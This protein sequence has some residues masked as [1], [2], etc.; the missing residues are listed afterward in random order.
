MQAEQKIMS[1]LSEHDTIARTLETY[2]NG[3]MSGKGDD[4]KPAFHRD[5][6]IFGYVGADLFGGPIKQLFDWV[7]QNPPAKGLQS[8]ITGIDLMGTIA[9]ARLELENWN[10]HRFTDMFTLLKTDGQWKI[11]SKVF[12]LHS[13]G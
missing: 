12:Y 11:I 3:G 7:D 1:S 6:T 10:G 2:I 5:A 13:E 9:T 8:R 4:M